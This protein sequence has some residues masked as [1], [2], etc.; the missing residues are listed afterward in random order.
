MKFDIVKTLKLN[1]QGVGWE[2]CYLSFYPLNIKEAKVLMSADAKDD[3]S[4]VESAVDLL[5]SKFASGKL[6]SDGKEVDVKVEDLD[7]LPMY[8][9]TDCIKLLSGTDEKKIAN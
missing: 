7:E 2:N 1:D 9:L 6:L 4:K 8:L 3:V 5:K